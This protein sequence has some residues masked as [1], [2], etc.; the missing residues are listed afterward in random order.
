MIRDFT[1]LMHCKQTYSYVYTIAII[2]AIRSG[3]YQ[4]Q[5]T[6]ITGLISDI[7]FNQQ[8]KSN[9]DKASGLQL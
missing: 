2:T 1:T 3:K 6:P 4:T 7:K 9:I 8:T 5:E